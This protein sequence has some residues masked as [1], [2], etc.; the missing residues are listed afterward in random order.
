MIL[1]RLA[2]VMLLLMPGL[3]L[4]QGTDDKDKDKVSNDDPGR[5]LQMPPASTETKE[6]L[7]D[8]ERFQRRGAWERALKSLYTIPDDQA[9]R[10]VDGEKGFIIPVERRRRSILAALPPAGQAACRL[11]YDAEAKKLLDE[12]EG[13]DGAEEPRA[14]LLGVFHHVG[15][16]QRR[17][18]AGGS[19]LRAGAIRPRGRLLA[20]G[21]ARAARYR[22]LAGPPGREGRA[23]PRPRGA[24]VRVRAGALRASGPIP[25]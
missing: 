2:I 8:F 7:E 14:G 19:V 6:A 23:G 25:G 21:P 5:P 10:F 4:G 22:P 11:F 13:A 12:A 24:T 9:R 3:V 1:M 16:R 15:R 20:V 18:S 17:R